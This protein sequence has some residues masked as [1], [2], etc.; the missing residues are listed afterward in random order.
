[1]DIVVALLKYVTQVE[2]LPLRLSEVHYKEAQMLVGCLSQ[3]SIFVSGDFQM[4]IQAHTC[5]F[6]H[7]E[8]RT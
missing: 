4:E 8:S 7:T 2:H 1:M 6:I 5:L 3:T